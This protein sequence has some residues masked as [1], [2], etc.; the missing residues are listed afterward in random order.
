MEAS[1]ATKTVTARN[2]DPVFTRIGTGFYVAD[3]C[4][5]KVKLERVKHDEWICSDED[6]E[7]ILGEGSTRNKAMK[8]AF[9]KIQNEEAKRLDWILIDQ[10]Y[11]RYTEPRKL[12]RGK[13]NGKSGPV[14][15]KPQEVAPAQEI[16]EA[17]QQEANE[18][19]AKIAPEK[20][21][22]L[23]TRSVMDAI[24]KHYTIKHNERLG[25]FWSRIGEDGNLDNLEGPFDNELATF[26]NILLKEEII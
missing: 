9:Y 1:E 18:S 23:L 5:Y 26:E 10:P 16:E 4:G 11:R 8:D 14:E 21:R 7:A 17:P 19:T 15:E 3:L 25:Y 2:N 6:S 12:N 22:R 13:S 20:L 24:R